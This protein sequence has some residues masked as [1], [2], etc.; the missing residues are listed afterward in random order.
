MRA[1]AVILS[2]CVVGCAARA[3]P[4]E[5]L[6]GLWGRGAA[7]CAMGMGV[8]FE[9]N[10]V[11]ADRGG[12]R[13]LWFEAPHYEVLQSGAHFQVRIT[14]RLPRRPGGVDVRGGRGALILERNAS[15][16]L[17]VASHQFIDNQTGSARVSLARQPIERALELRRCGL[18]MEEAASAPKNNGDVSE[19]TSPSREELKGFARP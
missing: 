7:S 18:A 1:W 11:W 6:A 12:A 17:A 8:R 5:E 19:E 2:L 3:G 4:P 9:Q 15:G 14:Y 10:G 13:D 16:R